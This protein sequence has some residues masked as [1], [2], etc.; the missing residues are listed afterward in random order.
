MHQPVLVPYCGPEKG[1]TA[2]TPGVIAP[3]ALGNYQA[4]WLCS[5]CL[6]PLHAIS[7]RVTCPLHLQLVLSRDSFAPF[8]GDAC[9]GVIE[10]SLWLRQDAVVDMS[11]HRACVYPAVVFLQLSHAKSCYMAAY[12]LATV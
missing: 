5:A 2:E 3:A 4:A 1:H 6:Q 12:I 8:A 9:C 7:G 11:G 10:A